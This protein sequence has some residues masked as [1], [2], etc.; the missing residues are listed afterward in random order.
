MQNRWPT[1]FP[2][3][4]VSFF[5]LERHLCKNS[6]MEVGYVKSIEDDIANGYE[7]K[8]PFSEVKTTHC[9]PQWYL[10]HHPVVNPNKPSTIRRVCNAA[11]RFAGISLNEDLVSGPHLLSD[12]IGIL[13]RF[14]LFK[15]LSADI[16]AMFMQAEVP[17]HEQRFL[18]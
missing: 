18:G 7:R 14:R 17:E 15:V 3:Q 13:I 1:I 6:E 16:E 2:W 4:N 5:W 11:A 12:L 9:L 10:P 8:V